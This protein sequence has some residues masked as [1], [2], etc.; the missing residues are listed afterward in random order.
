MKSAESSPSETSGGELGGVV[1]E[2]E[3]SGHII[4]SLILP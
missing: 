4:D 3:L 2:V 1:E